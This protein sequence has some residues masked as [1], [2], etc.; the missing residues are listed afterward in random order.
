MLPTV[1]LALLLAAPPAAAVPAL[2]ARAQLLSLLDGRRFDE[3]LLH[4]L[5]AHPEAAVREGAARVAGGLAHPGALTLVRRLAGDA[6]PAVRAAAAESAGRLAA[7]LGATSKHGK[8]AA[9]VLRR[10]LR[11]GSPE[12]R[13][14]A[15]WGI[16]A[17]EFPAGGRWLLHHLPGER[18]ATVRAACLA[19]LWRQ[20]PEGGVAAAAAALADPSPQVR[21]AAAWS[22][23]RS[24]GGGVEEALRRAAVSPDP[25][26]RSLAWEGVRRGG[27]QGL[28]PLLPAALDDE[29]DRVRVAAL[30]G[31]ATVVEAVRDGGV[32][33]AMAARVTALV[34]LADPER[35]HERVMAIRLAGAAGVAREALAACVASREPWVAGEGL[36]ALAQQRAPGV[37]ETAEKWLAGGEV[38]ERAA[39]VRAL[40]LLPEGATL[41]APAVADPAPAVRLALVEAAAALP[42]EAATG[43]LRD[44]L[45]DADGAVR[46]A[47][48]TA[49]AERR[50]LPERGRLRS[51]LASERHTDARVALVE[52]LAAAGEP[53]Q[54]EAEL[55]LRLLGGDDPVVARAAWAALRRAGRL[56]PLPPVATGWDAARY[57]EVAEW[58]GQPRVLEIV[59][60]RGTMA[61][62]LDVEHAPLATFRLSE[63]ASSG[64]FDGLTVHRVVPNF[65]VQGGDPRGDGWGGPPF[66]LRHELSLAAYDA[67]TVGL[68]HSGPDTAGSQFFVTLTPQPHLLGR[69]PVVGRVTAGFDV[70]KRLRPGD[71]ILRVRAA[72]TAPHVYPVWYGVLDPARLDAEIEGWEAERRGYAP[73]EDLLAL[74]RTARLRYGITVAMGTWCGDSREQIPHL[75]A[76]LAA[77][78]DASPFAPP[79]LVGGDRSKAYPPDRFP[80]G[81]VER[82]PTIVVTLE[83]AEVGRIVETPASGSLE[84]D[85]VAI[86]A[87]Y[88]G[89][90]LPAPSP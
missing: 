13:R 45:T 48:V 90:E 85:L 79:L 57:R 56:R 34:A 25:A 59:T 7:D 65:V 62:E 30:G 2:E 5:A 21:Y 24:K 64:F 10:L 72:T 11:D 69:Y 61:V 51:L 49:L 31:A 35:V 58:A 70:A 52:A 89:W 80:F 12:V 55:L 74:L 15:A 67:A 60:V 75:Q 81:A 23:A 38:G 42:G 40:A 33:D 17:G 46:A 19:E 6:S 76:I 43:L 18:D 54:P 77:L 86:L 82:V 63:L 39:A 37:R 9:A 83:G 20:A 88:E 4:A 73:R 27:W 32:P 14:A 78:G 44:L 50:A 71:R 26:V 68:A 8:G 53:T 87:P 29:D 16:A 1:V 36:L 3:A 28:W 22:L 84:E 66:T 47:V 41:V